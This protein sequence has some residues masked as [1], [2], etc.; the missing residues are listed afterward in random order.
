M[1][2][3]QAGQSPPQTKW[4]A[5]TTLLV[6]AVILACAFLIVI[7]RVDLPYKGL[8]VYTGIATL[9]TAV[10]ASAAVLLNWQES[11]QKIAAGGA[12]AVAIALSVLIGPDKAPETP[13]MNMTYYISFPD[14]KVRTPGDLLATATINDEGQTRFETRD[15][16]YFSRAPGG[17]AVKL[18]IPDVGAHDYFTLKIHSEKEKKTWETASLRFT[19]SFMMVV[20]GD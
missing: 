8:F 14:G 13:R 3:N 18:T 16:L 19:E 4:L 2:S 12:A 17:T 11:G 1:A 20:G 5:L 9:L 7:M 6:G 10:G 15:R